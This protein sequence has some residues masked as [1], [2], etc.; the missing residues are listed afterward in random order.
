VQYR[1]PPLLFRNLGK[2]R[3]ENVSALV[4]S[5]FATPILARG[6]AHADFDRDGDLDV[7]M[8]TNGGS[9]VLLRNDGGN[10]NHWLNVRLVGTKANRSGL[11]AVV[12][13]ESAGGKQWDM[14]HGG[15]SYCS[16]SD[17]T[18]TFGLG[19]DDV[20]RKLS[21][22]WPS[23]TR[24]SFAHVAANQFLTIHERDELVR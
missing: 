18:L 24:Q 11:G 12:R 2:G 19:A 9:P 21:V 20:I 3:F 23:G 15:G 13:V 10:R 1:E 17:L 4:G 14:L 7:L 16:Q 5:D 6:A 8:T 22:E